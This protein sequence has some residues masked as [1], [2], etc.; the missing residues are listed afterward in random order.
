MGPCVR[1]DDSSRGTRPRS[2]RASRPSFAA[3]CRP[4]NQRGRSAIPRGRQRDPQERA[5][6][7]P[8]ARCT[9]G[10]ACQGSKERRTRAYRFSGSSPAFPAQW[11]YGLFRAL[12]GDRLLATVIP[13]KLASQEL[14]A[15][16]EASG[17]HDFAVR[18]TRCSSSAHP[19]PPHPAPRF[20]TIA[21]RPSV[22][23]D[24]FDEAGD[25]GKKGSGIFFAKGL[26]R[27][28]VIWPTGRF[29]SSFRRGPIH[30]TPSSLRTQGPITPGFSK[31]RRRPPHR[32]KRESSAPR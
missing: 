16:A 11:F 27:E 3:T 10:L 8:G 4:L 26:D 22:G 12:P 15:S 2:R 1:R 31:E 14:D 25:L 6:G 9:R 13:Q 17:P 5:Q 21:S 7:R 30:V 23:R 19:R 32:Q 29:L 24:G 18:V 20:V 28:S